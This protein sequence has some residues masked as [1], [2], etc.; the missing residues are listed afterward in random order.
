MST[1]SATPDEY[2]R[3]VEALTSDQIRSYLLN[4]GY[5]EYRSFSPLGTA[6]LFDEGRDESFREEILLTINDQ[7]GDATLRKAQALSTLA[8]RE[9]LSELDL[10]TKIIAFGKISPRVRLETLA[11]LPRAN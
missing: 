5:R 3:R 4:Q 11:E 2:R 7:V 1:N 9:G 8:N 6:F 10:I